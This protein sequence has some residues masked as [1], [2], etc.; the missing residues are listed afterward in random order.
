MLMMGL[1]SESFVHTAIKAPLINTNHKTT[2]SE[3]GIFL[4]MGDPVK[5]S[6]FEIFTVERA[7]LLWQAGIKQ[8][9]RGNSVFTLIVVATTVLAALWGWHKGLL[10]LLLRLSVLLLAYGLA[11]QQTPAL[12]AYFIKTM[13]LSEV[14]AWPVAGV[15]LFL[16]GSIVFGAVAKGISFLLVEHW[17]VGKKRWS[18]G[19]C[20]AFLGC[21]VGLLLVWTV[22]T[23]QDS[24]RLRQHEPVVQ[25]TAAPSLDDEVRQL[26][27]DM[28]AALAGQALEGSAAAPVAQALVRNPVSIGQELQYLAQKPELQQLFQD[29]HNYAVLVRGPA[30]AVAQLPAFRALVADERA[31]QF[32]ALVGLQGKDL[33]EQSTTLASTLIRYA[34]NYERLRAEPQ[35]QAL[36]NDA[37][38]RE[39]WQQGN[40]LALLT[41]PK[42]RQMT[43]LL[44]RDEAQSKELSPVLSAVESSDTKPMVEPI[45]ADQ[46]KE[47]AKLLYRWKDEKGRLHI[48]EQAPP[49]GVKADV[50]QPE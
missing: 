7:G 3:V 31:M 45:S 33:G 17:E 23:L 21:G 39:Q 16:G 18:G 19:L 20:G 49:E 50:I 36:M 11:W 25:A 26:S 28:M 41:N 42:V 1:E 35:F 24:Q 29:P 40:L 38:L 15:L 8:R 46:T 30:S 47:P 22:G 32:L 27:G 10:H 6:G 44:S 48:T 5:R 4:A 13:A 2:E 37:A 12:A 34:G 43:E 9:K 14:A